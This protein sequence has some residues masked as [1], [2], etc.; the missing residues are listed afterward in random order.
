LSACS[1]R[2][3]SPC[4]AGAGGVCGAGTDAGCANSGMS[5]AG[6]GVGAGVGTGVGKGADVGPADILASAARGSSSSAEA[7]A[8]GKPKMPVALDCE[9]PGGP[10][11]WGNFRLSERSLNGFIHGH[12][13]SENLHC[14]GI[15]DYIALA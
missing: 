12:H 13:A 9:P 1:I 4:C 2:V 6:A 8:E 10:S 5:G 15:Q 14:S 11:E 3:N 7:G